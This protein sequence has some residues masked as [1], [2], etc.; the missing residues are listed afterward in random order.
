MNSFINSTNS[1]YEEILNNFNNEKAL[2]EQT[3][4]N[5]KLENE[6]L[7][8]KTR[9]YKDKVLSLEME[10]EKIKDRII[11]SIQTQIEEDYKTKY[12]NN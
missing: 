12:L 5:Q 9:I 2:L 6:N 11:S 10:K 3:I 4:H 1:K 8:S 7:L